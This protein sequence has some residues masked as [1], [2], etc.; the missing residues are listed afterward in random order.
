MKHNYYLIYI[1]K[2]MPIWDIIKYKA[3]TTLFLILSCVFLPIINNEPRVL[4]YPM[5][6]L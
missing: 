6:T 1:E 3:T 4:L 5:L 2:M